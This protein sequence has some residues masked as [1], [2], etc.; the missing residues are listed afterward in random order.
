MFITIPSSIAIPPSVL[1]GLKFGAAWY[2]IPPNDIV[3]TAKAI[4]HGDLV[5]G[6]S[7]E[8]LWGISLNDINRRFSAAPGAPQI[9]VPNGKAAATPP[10]PISEEQT[11]S[12]PSIDADNQPADVVVPTEYGRTIMEPD[13]DPLPSDDI[14]SEGPGEA[15]LRALNSDVPAGATGNDAESTNWKDAVRSDHTWM[16]VVDHLRKTGEW[17]GKNGPQPGNPG[18]L[19]PPHLLR[20]HDAKI[21]PGAATW[22]NSDH[23]VPIEIID[24]AP[25]VGRGG[26]LYQRVRNEYGKASSRWTRSGLRNSRRNGRS[27][28]KRSHRRMVSPGRSTPKRLGL[29]NPRPTPPPTNF[30]RKSSSSRRT[31]A[32]SPNV[33]T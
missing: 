18:C 14:R 25:L 21:K 2:E 16:V 20:A 6:M 31:A 8:R 1:S 4:G 32:R 12:E 3:L 26:L 28:P 22:A 24:E 7:L 15:P 17:N 10:A 27:G 23:D 29:R 11:F 19:V 5:G 33:S 9:H 30:G 13:S